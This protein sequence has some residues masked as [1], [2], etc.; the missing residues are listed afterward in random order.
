MGFNLITKA[1]GLLII[2]G[3][4]LSSCD[5]DIDINAS[6]LDVPIVY[7]LLDTES[8]TQYLKLNKTYL[9]SS[10][11]IENP[12]VSD[13]QYFEGNIQ[14]VME[15]WENNKPVEFIDFYPTY[16]V[17]KT[18]GFFPSD[19]NLLYKADATIK[20]NSLYMVSIYLEDRE[21][22]IHAST[23]TIGDLKVIDPIDLEVRKISL[24]QGIN[25]T[26]RWQQVANAG[27]Y[28]VVIRF[29]YA[30]T[31]DGIRSEKYL[32]WPQSFT[33]PLSNVD[34]LSKD[35]SGT[36]FFYVLEE[37]IPVDE[38][39]V[40]EAL[41]VDFYILSGGSEIKFYIESTSPSEGALMERP[42]YTNMVNGIGVFSSMATQKVEGL[43]L[44]STTIDS[45]AY[46]VHTKD[47]MF[48]DHNGTR[49][50]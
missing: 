10:A 26:T 20:S 11:A 15:R 47:L 6:N 18:P 21:K 30:E 1:T 24:N 17:P 41:G 44:A 25:Y 5:T 46:G 23:K 13:S 9:V 22:I 33:N 50:D 28:Q 38:N 4:L 14:I 12:P 3:A 40:R 34:Y 45:I 27:I 39:V 29:H 31:K 32:D 16:E 35:I 8:P 2:T 42:V 36:R 43:V 48:L 7:C 37:G 49:I 19:Q